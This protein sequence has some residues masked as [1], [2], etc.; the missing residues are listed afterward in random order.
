MSLSDVV[1]NPLFVQVTSGLIAAVV[2]IALSV[3]FGERAAA[4]YS[5]KQ[6][7]KREHHLALLE[8]PADELIQQCG[9]VRSCFQ[10]RIGYFSKPIALEAQILPTLQGDQERALTETDFLASHLETGYPETF[11]KLKAFRDEW[12]RHAL[13]VLVI[14]EETVKAMRA[15]NFLPPRPYTGVP[16]QDWCDYLQVGLDL[17]S[18]CYARWETGRQTLQEPRVQ[19]VKDEAGE[20]WVVNWQFVIARTADQGKANKLAMALELGAMTEAKERLVDVFKERDSLT[21]MGKPIIE[22]LE[23]LRVLVRAGVPLE[24]SCVAGQKAE[25]RFE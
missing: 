5:L 4:N 8:K 10:L 22:A 20:G 6:G 14:A 16:P 12:N 11:A 18:V 21:A 3:R 23:G 9:N 13:R 17:A 25:P 19:Q 7:R 15:D 2:S 1:S 24:G